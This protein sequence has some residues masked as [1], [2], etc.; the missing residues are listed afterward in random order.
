MYEKSIKNNNSSDFFEGN[1]LYVYLYKK[2]EKLASALYMVTNL[3]NNEEILRDILREKSISIFSGIMQLQ[4]VSLTNGKPVDGTEVEFISLDSILSSITETVSL[5][6]IANV[7]GYVSEMNFSVLRREY[8]DLGTLIKTRREDIVSDSVQLPKEF[9]DVPNLYETRTLQQDT[10]KGKKDISIKDIRS[11]QNTSKQNIQKIYKT[12]T[13]KR[14][15]IKD[16]TNIVSSTKKQEEVVYPKTADI[17]HN[18]RRNAILELLQNKP[19]VT[20][21][22]VTNTIQGCSSKTLQR[23]L[24]SLVNEGILKKEGERRWSTYSLV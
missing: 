18:N 22:D 3:I 1:H 8:V 21:K 14:S 23:E 12:P 2:A 10:T 5:L 16:T 17:R 7:S 4:R 9:F 6:E 20:V 15:F 19:S 24:L 13:T 11:T